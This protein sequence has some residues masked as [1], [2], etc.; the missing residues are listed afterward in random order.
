MNIGNE[1]AQIRYC[2]N[3]DEIKNFLEDHNLKFDHWYMEASTSELTDKKGLYIV[4][5][6][7]DLD[8]IFIH[9]TFNF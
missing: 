9:L 3:L 4:A 5:Y 6:Y 7:Q 2:Q 1:L 8:G